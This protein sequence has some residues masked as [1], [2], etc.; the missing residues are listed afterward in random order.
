[1]TGSK[2][3]LGTFAGGG[4]PFVGL[5]IDGLVTSL[6]EAAAKS[7][8]SLPGDALIDLLEDWPRHF[9]TLVSISDAVERDGTPGAGMDT[10]RVLPPIRRPSKI[11]NAAANYSGHLTEMAKYAASGGTAPEAVYKGDKANSQPYLFFKAPSAL[12]GAFDPIVLPFEGAEIDW[13]AELAVVIG[14]RA[15]RVKAGRALEHVAG[16]MTTN[17]VSC[18]SRLFRTD[19]P[20]FKTDWMSSKSWDTFAPTGPFFVPRQFVPDYAQLKIR[21]F[22]NG[23]QRQDGLAGDMIFSPEEQ[24]EHASELMTLEPGDM[25]CTGTVAGVGQG[26]GNYLK[27]G[28]VIECEVEGLGR[29]RNVV[30]PAG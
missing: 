20:N 14:A 1:M 2:F 10:L 21:L 23:E 17:D 27:P 29:Q 30:A 19:R 13:E 18:R 16:Y 9:E 25:F 22:V 8:V 4:R 28:D 7:G 12:T 26:S 11:M 24:I 5:V 3:A 6:P 15:R